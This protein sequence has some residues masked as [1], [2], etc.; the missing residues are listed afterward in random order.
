MPLPRVVDAWYEHGRM[1]TPQIGYLPIR[2]SGAASPE[3]RQ[4]V[5]RADDA[6]LDHVSVGDH[7]SF[8]VGAGFD[9]LVGAASVL[10]VSDRLR[11]NSAVYLLPLRHPVLVAR[12]LADLALLA[13][14][15]F[16]FG[17]GLG[18]EDP[19]ELEICGVDPK[20]RGR[21]MDECLELV[22][23]LLTGQA[24]D[25]AGEFFA[26]DGALIA[27]P[28]TEPVP[29]VVGGRSDAAIRRAGRL[30]DGWFGIWVSA[31][32]YRAAVEQ[33]HE[34]AAEAGRDAPP[35]TNALNVWC[36]VGESSDE[37]RHHVAAGMETFYQLPYERFE[38]WSPAGTPAEIADFLAPYVEAGCS[39]FNLIVQGASAEAEIEAAAEIRARM[40]EAT[41]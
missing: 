37:A 23:A 19:H 39:I 14:G 28:P 31:A 38:K 40:L 2:L 18:G 27:P 29:I 17:V 15:R 11:S 1:T 35:A 4:L 24:V 20:T 3:R 7:V 33:M 30:G 9:A 22:R 10:G 21:R 5:Q 25:H 34:A 26:V 32:R 41:A 16:V 8:F 6:G 36:G 13:P 12:Q